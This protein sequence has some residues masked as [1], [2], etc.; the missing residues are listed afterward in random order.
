MPQSPIV[1][2]GISVADLVTR[3]GFP[4]SSAIKGNEQRRLSHC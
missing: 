4:I 1:P 3:G 2:E